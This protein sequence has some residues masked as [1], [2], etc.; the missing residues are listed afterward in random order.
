MAIIDVIKYDG[1]DQ[2]FAWK[3]PS[4]DLRL[5]TQL[6]VKPA[7]TAFFIKGGKILDQFESGTHTLNSGNIPLLNKL[8]NIP[9]G[10]DSPF[11][12]EVW[13]INR[14]SKLDN[15]WG[16]STPLQLE[17]PKYKIIVP[18]RAFGQFGFKI[19][20]PKIFLETLIGTQYGFSAD[21]IVN[22]FKGKIISSVTTLIYQKIINDRLSILEI[23]KMLDDMSVFCEGQLKGEFNKYGIEILNFYFMSINVPDNDPSVIK[24]KEIK[25]KAMYI[26]TVGKDVYS[27][28]RSMDVMETAAGNEGNSGNLMGAGLGLGMGLGI[29]GN[30]GSQMGNISGQINTNL[31]QNMINCSICKAVIQGNSRFCGSCGA[32][33]STKIKA[34]S[35]ILIC[36]KCGKSTPIGQRFCMHCGD[37][38]ILCKSCNT[39]NPANTKFCINCGKPMD[40]KCPKCNNELLP[41]A[42][43]CGNCGNKL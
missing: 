42:K 10:G 33:Q 13:F 38:F 22:Y 15:R 6:I 37:E 25:E 9:F 3:F 1:N 21:K 29:G 34:E 12:A 28:D 39:D 35:D 17:D 23:P 32:E 30:M 14:I 36:D 19:S 16:T 40:N 26:N 7:Q 43:F 24:L 8:L 18:V 41:N 5:G 31:Q 11:Q 2:E 27:F 4:Y 20:E